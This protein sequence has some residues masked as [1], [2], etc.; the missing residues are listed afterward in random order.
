M[1]VKLSENLEQLEENDIPEYHPNDGEGSL[2]YFWMS[3]PWACSQILEV[4]GKY[5]KIQK[6]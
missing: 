2:F 6:E 1:N 4:L 3:E 5:L